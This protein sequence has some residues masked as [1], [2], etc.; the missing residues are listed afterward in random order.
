M[1][2]SID[3]HLLAA[4]DRA[5]AAEG[6]TRSGFLSEAARKLIGGVTQVGSGPPGNRRRGDRLMAVL[7]RTRRAA[8]EGFRLIGS[9]HDEP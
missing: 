1:N 3:E 9:V 6:K 7:R 5:A 4:I 8:G 2:I